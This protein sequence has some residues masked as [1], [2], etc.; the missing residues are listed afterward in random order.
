MSDEND[1]KYSIMSDPMKFITNNVMT[2][3]GFNAVHG[4]NP[5]T[6][7]NVFYLKKLE[8][9]GNVNYIALSL[10]GTNTGLS[11]YWVPQGGSCLVPATP[12]AGCI[13]FTPDFSGCSIQ[14]DM[15]SEGLL[16]IYHVQGGK[17]NYE[18][19]YLCKNHGLGRVVSMS[20][21]DYGNIDNPRGFAFLHYSASEGW[22]IYGQRQIGRGFS[23]TGN[24]ISDCRSIRIERSFYKDFKKTPEEVK[25]DPPS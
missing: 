3:I 25:Y 7:P 19:E 11:G 12:N 6:G 4:P 15:I 18:N 9:I 22:R 13:V 20:A 5:R 17:R 1:F 8:T 10:K 14:V 16:N 21:D 2:A 23:I 24:V